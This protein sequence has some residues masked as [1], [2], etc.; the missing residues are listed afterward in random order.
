MP[1]SIAR[2]GGALSGR[3]IRFLLPTENGANSYARP[4]S[5]DQADNFPEATITVQNETAAGGK[6]LPRCSAE[7]AGGDITIAMLNSGLLLSQL[8]G[9]EG[10]SYDF[11]KFRWIGSMTDDRRVLMVGKHAGASTLDEMRGK[12][13]NLGVNTMASSSSYEAR[14]LNAILGLNLQIVPGFRT[15]ERLKGSLPANST[16][17][18]EVTRAFIR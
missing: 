7:N 18:A 1:Y 16:R 15:S 9:E 8:L 17:Y 5:E 14:M 12:R 3:S 13:L 4:F 11:R 2:A 10:V 6:L